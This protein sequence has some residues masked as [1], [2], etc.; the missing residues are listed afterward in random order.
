MLTYLGVI[1]VLEEFC[2][3]TDN[4]LEKVEWICEVEGD[5]V[6]HNLKL[7]NKIYQRLKRRDLYKLEKE[8]FLS[9]KDSLDSLIEE[10]N[11][12]TQISKNFEKNIG[13]RYY[14]DKIT[15]GLDEKDILVLQYIK[16]GQLYKLEE[17]NRTYKLGCY[18]ELMQ[19]FRY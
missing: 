14:H 2:K 12:G 16:N 18:K 10:Y 11:L 13:W 4:I 19:Q 9:Q 5:N 17:L 3:I 7:A 8:I 15:F 1:I 6:D